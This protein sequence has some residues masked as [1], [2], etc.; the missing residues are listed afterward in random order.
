[1]TPDETIR[2]LLANAA[3]AT[4]ERERAEARTAARLAWI[5]KALAA[6]AA[7]QDRVHQAWKRKLDTLPD[8]LDDEELDDLPNPPEQAEADALWSEIEAVRDRDMWPRDL[9]WTV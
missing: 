7:A 5:G 8:D 1:M 3:Q 9:Y 6:F 2:A 4:E